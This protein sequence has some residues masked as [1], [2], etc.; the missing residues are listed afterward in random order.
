MLITY[1][2]MQI[3]LVHDLWFGN[4]TTWHHYIAINRYWRIFWTAH[5]HNC[6]TTVDIKLARSH[7]LIH[8]CLDKKCFIL[9][10]RKFGKKNQSKNVCDTSQEEMNFSTLVIVIGLILLVFYSK[11]NFF[12]LCY[13]Y[14]FRKQEMFIKHLFP[15]L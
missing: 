9:S 7:Y 4:L 3:F 13:M 1:R 5:V 8:F 11:Y 6:V 12:T 15:L 2:R 10:T 14:L